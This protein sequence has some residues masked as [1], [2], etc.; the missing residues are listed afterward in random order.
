MSFLYPLFLAGMVAIGVPIV[1][2]MIRRHTRKRITFSS[3]MF[4]RTTAPRLR[5]R[6][7][8]ENLPLLILRCLLLCLL[9]I[10]FARPL[11]SRQ[12]PERVAR[13]GRRIV[14]LVDT[15]ASMRRTGL[16]DEAIGEVRSALS[17]IEPSDRLCLMTFDRNTQTQIGFEQWE[18][19]DLSQRKAAVTDSLSE[20]SPGWGSTDLGRALTSA[21]E[22]IEDDEVNDT[23]Q[24]IG[25]HQ[26]VLIGDLQ[27]G[28]DLDALATYEWP[29]TVELVL[30]PVTASRSTN[31][32]LEWVTHRDHLASPDGNEATSIRVTNSP[33]ATIEQFQL[34]WADESSA[35]T[36]AKPIETY[37]PAGHSL[38]VKVPAPADPSAV[39]RL[40]LTG[41]DH[42]F[43]N[44]L[45]VAPLLQ[46]QI[47]ILYVGHDDPNDPKD[48]LFYVRRAFGATGTL[49]AHV[50]SHLGDEVLAPNEIA[51]AHLIIATD[52]TRQENLAALRR[53]IEAGGTILLAMK[54]ADAGAVLSGLTGIG[55]TVAEEADVG[56]YAMLGRIEFSH[57]LL[58]VFSDPRFGDFT[59]VHFWKYRRVNLGNLPDARVLARYDSDDPAWFEVPIGRGTLIVLT[60]GWHPSDSDLALSSKFV[61]L[62]YSILEYGGV[63]TGAQMQYFVG[64]PVPVAR[65]TASQ[66]TTLRIRKPDGSIV[67]LQTSA[68][69][70]TETD[71][72]GIYGIESSAGTKWFAVNIPAAE[73]RT[74]PMP[75]EELEKLGVALKSPNPATTEHIAKAAMNR[76]LVETENEQ[77]LWRWVLLAALAVLLMETWLAGWLT[78]PESES[79]GEQT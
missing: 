79:Q 1:L 35:Q 44:T 24:P 22:A 34:R 25:S 48:M 75:I 5:N 23:Q 57:P 31:A 71:T 18:S 27:Q 64:D 54:S 15:S 76:G 58:S 11:F 43:D 68:E 26:I 9:A 72:P 70:F 36:T 41:D 50:T 78:R 16:W 38:V 2:H 47:D 12:A 74:D 61:P 67:P 73:G 49:N 39:H 65:P 21:A 29:D 30:K 62:L 63:L 52:V 37:I 51:D 3:L 77:K 20:M 69:V 17:D 56:R 33:E 14:V 45:Y 13:A 66:R 6:S 59:K 8:L 19:L 53:H 7:R 32:A 55:N 46:Q 60:C 40:V 28:S 42:D 4:V 10:A